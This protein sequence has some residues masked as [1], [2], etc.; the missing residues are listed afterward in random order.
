MIEKKRGELAE[1]A[2]RKERKRKVQAMLRSL[3]LEEQG[4]VDKEEEFR[5]VLAKEEGDVKRLEKTSLTSILYS[6]I[7]K[8]EGQLDKEQR[9][10][11]AARLKYSAAVR[12]LEDL[13]SRL[14]SLS[15]EEKSLSGCEARYEQALEEL[16]NLMREDPA[17]GGR[18]CDLERQREDTMNQLRE[19]DE[20]MG[21]G[22]AALD[23]VGV[24]MG[25]LESAEG[26]GTWD[27][28]GG[29]LLSDMA[30]YSHLDDAQAAAEQLQVLLSRFHT[31]LA[32]VQM[33]GVDT[34][35][36]VDGF[37]RF[38]DYFFDGVFTDWAVLSRI[39]NSMES[40]KETGRQVEQVLFNLETMRRAQVSR[41]DKLDEEIVSLVKGN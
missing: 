17:M 28:L 2:A 3:K 14:E 35:V 33:V 38:A 9:E 23:Q 32:D 40:I 7:G 39:E 11:Y 31:E 24:I 1:L 29:G 5:Q 12:Q 41:R 25:S 34:T 36:A 20:A 19:I 8:K 16:E 22:R 21:A 27:L 4:L 15:R 26:W 10:A 13:R 30:K 18:I 6:I 37:L